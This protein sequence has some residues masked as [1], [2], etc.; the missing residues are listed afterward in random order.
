M[1]AGEQRP[2]NGEAFETSGH[3]QAPYDVNLPDAD[4]LHA[5][6]QAQEGSCVFP[7]AQTPWWY[8]PTRIT[9]TSSGLRRR[10]LQ[11]CDSS[12]I[13]KRCDGM[14][15][16]KE[17]DLDKFSH[18]RHETGI[19]LHK[20]NAEFMSELRCWLTPPKPLLCLNLP[21]HPIL[22]NVDCCSTAKHCLAE[23]LVGSANCH[24][25]KSNTSSM[26]RRRDLTYQPRPNKPDAKKACEKRNMLGADCITTATYRLGNISGPE[27]QGDV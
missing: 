5:V 26:R 19:H 10:Q 8:L 1:R 12:S 25:P 7:S 14:G 2:R 18:G 11:H 3:S 24:L 13:H 4:M 21:T 16:L 20:S 17:A 15:T 9:V 6:L 22:S 23:S 27:L